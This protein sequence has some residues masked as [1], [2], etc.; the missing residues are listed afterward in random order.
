MGTHTASAMDEALGCKRELDDPSEY[1]KDFLSGR[2]ITPVLVTRHDDH[3]YLLFFSTC[4]CACSCMRNPLRSRVSVSE[5]RDGVSGQTP[6]RSGRGW[7]GLASS[8][9]SAAP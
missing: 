1:E 6:S 7:V 5:P 2:K 4:S 3:L 9:A 8:V